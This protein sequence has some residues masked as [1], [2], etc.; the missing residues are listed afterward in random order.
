LASKSGRLFSKQHSD[1]P[2]NTIAVSLLS[3]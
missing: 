1:M 2:G 3:G